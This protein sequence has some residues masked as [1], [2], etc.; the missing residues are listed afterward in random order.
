MRLG[1]ICVQS[2]TQMLLFPKPYAAP[3]LR[4]THA[5]TFLRSIRTLTPCRAQ[6]CS[7]C[8]VCNACEVQLSKAGRQKLQAEELFKEREKELTEALEAKQAELERQQC[9][10]A[11]EREKME[12]K[13]TEKIKKELAAQYALQEASPVRPLRHLPSPSKLRREMIFVCLLP[14]TGTRKRSKSCGRASNPR[15]KRCRRSRRRASDESEG[16][17]RRNIAEAFNARVGL[18]CHFVLKS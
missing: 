9:K 11:K 17:G 15:W 14:G 18:H 2:R 13:L 10:I 8:A 4:C 3:L 5:C 1:Y 16:R 6:A 7:G 12:E